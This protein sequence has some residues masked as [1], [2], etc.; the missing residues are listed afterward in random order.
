MSIY[1]IIVLLTLPAQQGQAGPV[2]ELHREFITA[3]SDSVCQAHAEKR[4]EEQRQRY[5]DSV[6]R[7]QAKVAGVCVLQ[8]GTP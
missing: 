3:S 2:T 5:A 7:L 1:L 8:G 6:R 4:A